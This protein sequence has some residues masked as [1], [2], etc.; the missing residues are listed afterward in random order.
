MIKARKVAIMSLFLL[1]INIV[2]SV[3]ITKTNFFCLPK[4]FHFVKQ[5]KEKT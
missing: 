4:S 5:K 3:F 1:L 2:D